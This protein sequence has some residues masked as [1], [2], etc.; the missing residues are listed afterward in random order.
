MENKD[1]DTNPNT[2]PNTD[3]SST[4]IHKCPLCL[5]ILEYYTDRYPKMICPKCANGENG[6]II[7]N[8]GND[9]SFS[10]IDIYGGFASHHK[11]SNGNGNSNSNGNSNENEIIHKNEHIC[12]INSIKCYASEARFG[13]IVIQTMN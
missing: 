9:V 2:N 11:I 10:N 8:F 5:S 3:T 12:W 1:K 7:D 6:K 13:G 4:I